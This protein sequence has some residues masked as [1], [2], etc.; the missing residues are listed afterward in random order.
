MIN[1]GNN[2]HIAFNFNIN[3]GNLEEYEKVIYDISNIS[4]LEY[5][6]EIYEFFTIY[7]LYYKNNNFVNELKDIF[8]LEKW[9]FSEKV[10]NGEPISN[11]YGEF[12]NIYSDQLHEEIKRLIPIL[13]E[14]IDSYSFT[15]FHKKTDKEVKALLE[16]IKE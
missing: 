6:N 8:K 10:G 12:L 7:Y 13:L 14:Q 1:A 11:I 4:K 16:T 15:A 5:T 2:P 3:P 9:I